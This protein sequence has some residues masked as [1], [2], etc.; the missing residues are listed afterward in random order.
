M[1]KINW[2]YCQNNSDEIISDGIIKLCDSEGRKYYDILST[3]PGNYLISQKCNHYYIGEARDVMARIVQQYNPKTSTFYKT[4][5]KLV[6]SNP[7]IKGIPVENFL[8]RFIQTEIG[9]KE[10]EDS[11]I[12]NLGTSLNKFQKGKRLKINLKKQCGLWEIVQSQ[13][14]ELLREGEKDL[15]NQKF[16]QWI[17]SNIKSTAG[18]YVVKHNSKILYIGESSNLNE[19][20]KTHTGRTYFSALRRHI[21]TNILGFELV[22]RNGKKKYFIDEEDERVTEFLRSTIAI[23]YPVSFGRYELEEYLIKKHKPMLNRK[24]NKD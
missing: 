14:D 2:K 4:F 3:Q 8:V 7:S 19:R 22:E 21:G 6:Q 12:V 9:R 17:N 5:Q 16:T 15:F 23:F 20:Y 11:G 13:K 10:I 18:V 24:A 1:S